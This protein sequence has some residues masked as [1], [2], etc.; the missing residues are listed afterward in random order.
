[1]QQ[2]R[3]ERGPGY[4]YR[5]HLTNNNQDTNKTIANYSTIKYLLEVTNNKYY[6]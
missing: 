6:K 4:I 1:M 5:I 2:C 3:R